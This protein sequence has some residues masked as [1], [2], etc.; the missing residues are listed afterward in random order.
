MDES[1]SGGTVSL[2]RDSKIVNV[3]GTVNAVLPKR[4]VQFDAVRFAL[5]D[6]LEGIGRIGNKFYEHTVSEWHGNRPTFSL[7]NKQLSRGGNMSI[8]FG[9]S[10]TADNLAETKRHP[11]SRLKVYNVID[12]GSAHRIIHAKNFP[13]M[14][15]QVGY[16]AGTKPGNYTFVQPSLREPPWRKSSSVPHEQQPRGFTK[17]IQEQVQDIMN[18]EVDYVIDKALRKAGIIG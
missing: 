11:T 12:Y 7:F 10:P 13:K 2:S 5:M 14:T 4:A 16:T 9:I 17:Q 3:G 15:F 1:R 6:W 8:S 18:T